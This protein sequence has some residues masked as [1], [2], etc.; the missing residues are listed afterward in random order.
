MRI[1]HAADTRSISVG[2]NRESTCRYLTW[3]K[4]ELHA[5]IAKNRKQDAL[6]RLE[7]PLDLRTSSIWRVECVQF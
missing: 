5:S 1:F 6:P 3:G 4:P 2:P 7:P